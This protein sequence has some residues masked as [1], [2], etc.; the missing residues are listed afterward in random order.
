HVNDGKPM[1]LKSPPHS[2]RV[3]TLRR[4][5]PKSRFV[6]MVRDPN[7]VFES[8]MKTY[9]A[10][11]LRYGLVPGLSNRELREVILAERLRCEEKLVQGLA[12]LE[13]DRL[14]VIKFE[15]L[16]ADPVATVEAL[17]RQFG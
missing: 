16:V 11:S 5:V 15:E 13:A 17:Y 3:R 14:A 10:F 2:Y 12:G 4:L 8:M 6:L 1:I 9:R 7:A